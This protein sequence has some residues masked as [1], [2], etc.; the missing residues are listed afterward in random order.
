MD[1]KS[2]SN[3]MHDIEI[4]AS[5]IASFG[6]LDLYLV[7]MLTGMHEECGG[8]KSGSCCLYVTEMTEGT[9]GCPDDPVGF[10]ESD[11]NGSLRFE[12]G[13]MGK[14]TVLRR[15]TSGER[16]TIGKMIEICRRY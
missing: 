11:A 16:G 14:E 12:N 13:R 9:R 7:R 15:P 6:G 3:R 1:G 5:Y 8:V 2:L 4:C 10:I